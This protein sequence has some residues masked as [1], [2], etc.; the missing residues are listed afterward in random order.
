MRKEIVGTGTGGQGIQL[1][2]H[3][4]SLALHNKNRNM[5]SKPDYGPEVR[6]GKSSAYS[7][8]KEFSEDW[9]E[10]MEIDILISLSQEGFDFW[11]GRIKKD[12]LVFYDPTLIQREQEDERRYYAVPASEIVAES[13]DKRVINM[14]I[15]GG[16]I[17]ISKLVSVQEIV[18]ALKQEGK[19]SEANKKALEEGYNRVYE[20]K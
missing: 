16:V 20:V 13:K 3:I 4:F 18:K 19:Y 10:V 6:G 8:M 15:L 12:A 5:A 11:L 14:A 1:M 17:K 9:P 7:V 2:I